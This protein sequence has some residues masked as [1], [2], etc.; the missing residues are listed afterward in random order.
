LK[1]DDMAK[2]TTRTVVQVLPGWFLATVSGTDEDKDAARYFSLDPIIAREISRLE[3]VYAGET[4][5]SHTTLPIAFGG[6][7]P[8]LGDWAVKRPDGKFDVPEETV[9]DTQQNRRG[10]P[11]HNSNLGLQHRSGEALGNFC[12]RLPQLGVGFAD[13]CTRP[14]SVR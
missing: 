2:A 8:A 1:E 6:V 9:E 13:W 11:S 14:V 5:V 4:H 12:R 7:R 10:K 3:T